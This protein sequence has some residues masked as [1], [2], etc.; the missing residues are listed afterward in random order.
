MY[1]IQT[2]IEINATP[3]KIWQVLTN[4][5]DFPKWSQFLLKIEGKPEIGTRLNVRINDGKS[6][7][8]FKPKLII[9]EAQQ[10]LRWLGSLGGMGF[11]FSGEHY[12]Q[13]EEAKAG[14]TRMVHGE[15]FSGWLAPLLWKSLDSNTRAGFE[16]FNQ[17]LKARVEQ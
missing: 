4:F 3:D 8:T 9:V 11:L 13:F 7:M 16:L 14:V 1:N 15:N 10:E 17:A 6:T 5:P 2:V 12:F